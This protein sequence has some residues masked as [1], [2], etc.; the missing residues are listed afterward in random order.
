MCSEVNS[1]FIRNLSAILRTRICL[2]A[3]YHVGGKAIL[4]VVLLW[5]ALIATRKMGVCVAFA[6]LV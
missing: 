2:Q 3:V 5:D 1:I 6:I 4:W